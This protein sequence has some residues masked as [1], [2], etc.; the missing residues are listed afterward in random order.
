MPF[1]QIGPNRSSIVIAYDRRAE[2]AATSCRV[3]LRLC[4]VAHYKVTSNIL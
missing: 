2:R 3:Q 4:A 1:G